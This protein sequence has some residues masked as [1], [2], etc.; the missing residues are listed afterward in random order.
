MLDHKV[1]RRRRLIEFAREFQR[2]GGAHEIEAIAGSRDATGNCA[3]RKVHRAVSGN[4][5][6]R[7]LERP[8]R[9]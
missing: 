1:N 9:E 5:A 2:V 6:A 3:P 8:G 7:L 4:P